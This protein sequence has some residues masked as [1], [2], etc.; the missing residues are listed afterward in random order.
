MLWH[1]N[2]E[3]CLYAKLTKDVLNAIWK[4]KTFSLLKKHC[5]LVLS[6]RCHNLSHQFK[7]SKWGKRTTCYYMSYIGWIWKGFHTKLQWIFSRWCGVW[8][9]PSIQEVYVKWGCWWLRHWRVMWK[10]GLEWGGFSRYKKWKS[11]IFIVDPCV[12]PSKKR[13]EQKGSRNKPKVGASI[14]VN[15]GR[16]RRA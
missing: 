4:W 16:K 3:L 6:T 5:E 14:L 9:G 2:V 1:N 15:H 12:P 10:W 13:G 7:Y 8:C 11:K